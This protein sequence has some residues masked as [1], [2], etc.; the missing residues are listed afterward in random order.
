MALYANDINLS[1]VGAVT[2]FLLPVLYAWL[3]ACAAVLRQLSADSSGSTF[4]PEH[5]KVANRAHVTSAIIVGISIGLFSKLPE[6]GKM[7]RR[8]RSHS[9]RALHLTSSFSSTGSPARCLRSASIR[10]RRP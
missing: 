8:S 1:V 5:S 6:G 9:S 10:P 3:G 4:H 7:H 2:G